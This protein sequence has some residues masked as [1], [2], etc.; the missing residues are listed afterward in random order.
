MISLLPLLA[1]VTGRPADPHWTWWIICYFFFGGIAGG[2]FLMAAVA[3][4]FGD[5]ESAPVVRIGYLLAAPLIALCGLL[6]TL[7]LGQPLRFW[8]MLI[9]VTTNQPAFKYWSPMSYGSWILS[10]FGLCS[11]AAFLLV[12]GE[13]RGIRPAGGLV[14]KVIGA[15]GAIFALFFVSYTGVLLNAT[16]QRVWGDNTLLGAL[17]A[18]SGISTGIAAIIL[19]LSLRRGRDAGAISRLERADLFAVGLELVILLALIGVL[20]AAGS[21]GALIAGRLGILFWIGVFVAGLL[22]PLVLYLRPRLL[23]ALTPLTA[24]SLAL[25]G[26]FILR[27]VVLFSAH[28]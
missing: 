7:D 27:V 28:A 13:V 11:G 16:N 9:N 21:V 20:A 2:A 14:R 10:G 23:G 12:L 3:D 17:F 26:G 19:V 4:F 22:V 18:V 5:G 8:H 15:L 25:I 1:P 24:A 6:L